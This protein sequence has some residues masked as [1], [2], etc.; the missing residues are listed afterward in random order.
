MKTL[1]RKGFGRKIALPG[2]PQEEWYAL[3]TVG[4]SPRR[5]GRNAKSVN[6]VPNLELRVLYEFV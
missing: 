5:P 6:S 4:L 1:G 3:K 2:S